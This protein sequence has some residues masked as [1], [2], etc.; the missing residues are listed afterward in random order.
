MS[1]LNSIVRFRTYLRDSHRNKRGLIVGSVDRITG[2]VRIGWS[3]CA[4]GRGDKFNSHMANVIA[5]GR[6]EKNPVIASVSDDW[7]SMLDPQIQ[8]KMGN[9]LSDRIRR[10]AN[11]GSVSMAMIEDGLLK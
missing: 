11:N 9:I 3:I 7:V 8:R 5:N 1:S 10:W 2:M 4:I 6:Y